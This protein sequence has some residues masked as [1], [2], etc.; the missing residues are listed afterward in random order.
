[1]IANNDDGDGDDQEYDYSIMEGHSIQHIPIYIETLTG[2]TFEMA[3]LPT[4]SIQCLKGK[5][6]SEEGIPM[7]RRLTSVRY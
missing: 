5:L 1:M 6:Q 2:T 3:I 4:D 7:V